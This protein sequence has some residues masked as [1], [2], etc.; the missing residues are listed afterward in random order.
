MT[1]ANVVNSMPG[2]L[3]VDSVCIVELPA[4]KYMGLVSVISSL[5]H[6]SVLIEVVI[7]SLLRNMQVSFSNGSNI[8]K[9]KYIVDKIGKYDTTTDELH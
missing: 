3:D 9:N 7:P 1:E 2:L 6:K 8:A 4:Y 5:D